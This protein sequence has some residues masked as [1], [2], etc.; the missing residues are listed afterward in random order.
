MSADGFSE[1]FFSDMRS[2]LVEA[3]GKAIDPLMLRPRGQPWFRLSPAE[4]KA[5]FDLLAAS[6][7]PDTHDEWRRLNEP[8]GK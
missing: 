7:E 2:V 6:D 1:F 8:E 4:A 5:L 3:E